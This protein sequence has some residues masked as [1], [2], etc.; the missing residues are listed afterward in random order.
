MDPYRSILYAA[1]RGSW[2]SLAFAIPDHPWVDVADGA[3]VR[4]AL[5][6]LAAGSAL[7]RLAEVVDEQSIVGDDAP[8]V[9]FYERPGKINS[10]LAVGADSTQVGGLSANHGLAFMGVIP[11]GLG[12]RLDG[13]A[14]SSLGLNPREL[15][16][17][18][19]RYKNGRDVAENQPDRLIIDFFGLDE[20][21]ARRKFPGA[22]QHVLLRVKPE[23]DDCRRQNHR[24]KWWI[25]GE[26]R[27]AMRRALADLK[28]YI[29]TVETSK[30]RYFVFLSGDVLPDQKLRVI[31]HSDAWVL[32]VLSGRAHT[33]WA[34]ATGS[35][36]GVGNDP[37]Y[38]NTSTFLPFP[39]PAVSG[40]QMFQIRA[41][42][43]ALDAHR[44]RQQAQHPK[45]TI[46]GMYN[47]LEKLRSG[48]PLTEKDRVIHEQGLVSV[49]KQIHDD[50]D[51][52]VFD[53]YGWPSTLTDEE[54]L[55]RLVA[56]N[57]ERAAEE[58]QGL[59]R[60]L[61]PE[62]QNPQG[63]KAATQ[64]SLVEA[65]LETAVP[66]KAAKGKKAAKLAWP[67]GLPARVVAARDLLAE[68]GEASAD[69]FPRRFKDVKAEQ[70]EKLLES[71]AAVGVAIETTAGSGARSWRLVR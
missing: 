65:G 1:K 8:A 18:I 70:A 71:L 38:N 11:V 57:H 12:F 68:I 17:I 24:E 67:K 7:G 41:L 44:K 50:L 36:M 29:V 33:T 49:L 52:A 43:E 63:T 39:F 62:F 9:K 51:A 56:L 30:H 21:E 46:T 45:L 25:F 64:V 55:E 66:A 31:A 13:G 3:A 16:P 14:V 6:V 37:V 35:W 47:V 20:E 60:W 23:R 19:R 26:T 32:G 2:V 28:R 58:K 40:S 69:D 42:G 48:E 10:N 59:V 53:A 27:P 15:P 5:T 4:V 22:Y 34:H 61:R 54:I